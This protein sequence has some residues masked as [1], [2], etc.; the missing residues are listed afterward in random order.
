MLNGQTP[1]ASSAD[2]RTRAAVAMILRNSDQGLEVLLIQRAAH[3]L[4][5]W[6]GHLAFPGGKVESGEKP[7]TAA[8]RETLEEVGIDLQQ[9]MYLGPLGEI[10]GLTLPVRVSGYVYFLRTEGVPVLNE[11]VFAS[12][13]VPLDTLM[14]PDRH[15]SAPVFFDGEA[16]Q[17]PAIRLPYADTPVLWGLTYRLVMQFIDICRF[18]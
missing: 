2:R 16:H 17:V 5:P 7:R 1:G 8:E 12:F 6:S 10:T 13:W 14:S 11:E 4:D 9:A 15:V 3:E 18:G